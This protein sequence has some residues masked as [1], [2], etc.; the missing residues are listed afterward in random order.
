MES[1]QDMDIIDRILVKIGNPDS[2][3]SEGGR[4]GKGEKRRER[5]EG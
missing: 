2:L 4:E 1:H 5:E 3:V